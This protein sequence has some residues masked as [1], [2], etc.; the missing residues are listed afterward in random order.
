MKCKLGLN[1]IIVLIALS[2]LQG[3]ATV[4]CTF[5]NKGLG[6]G[7]SFKFNF[8]KEECRLV[9]T[10][11]G[12]VVTLTVQYPEMK[13][14]G[15]RVVDDSVVVLRMSHIDSERYD[16]NGIVGTRE[17]DRRLGTIDI[18]DVGSV[19]MY[20]F[21]GKD[22]EV[23]F[24]RNMGNTYLAKRLVAGDVFVFY[25]YSKNHQDLEYLDATITDFLSQKLVR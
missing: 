16:Q 4:P 13:L 21:R 23:V 12:S 19:E 5:E 7:P 9:E 17:P 20:R 25:Q 15:A 2:P 10:R 22:G 18:Y 1:L 8:S 3:N 14:I 6:G 11:N 24:V